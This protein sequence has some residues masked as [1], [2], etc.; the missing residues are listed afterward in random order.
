MTE[1]HTT[2][3]IKNF[4]KKIPPAIEKYLPVQSPI[5]STAITNVIV[6]SSVDV[7]AAISSN[8]HVVE[9]SVS[10]ACDG[11]RSTPIP[12]HHSKYG[13]LPIHLH[14]SLE[15]ENNIQTKLFKLSFVLMLSY[16]LNRIEIDFFPQKS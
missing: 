6:S 11:N 10:I 5:D 16:N 4:I 12:A 13:D 8:I 7:D 3:A 2:K 9:T 1:N 14:Q 15:M